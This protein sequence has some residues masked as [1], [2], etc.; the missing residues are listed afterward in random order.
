[1]VL[2]ADHNSIL[3]ETLD[4]KEPARERTSDSTTAYRRMTHPAQ[5]VELDSYT[6]IGSVESWSLI[7]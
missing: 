6:Q 4:S 3:G 1:M 7:H 5:K 2:L